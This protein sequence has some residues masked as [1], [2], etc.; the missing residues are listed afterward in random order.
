[1]RLPRHVLLVVFAGANVL[2]S[3]ACE[4]AGPPIETVP[5]PPPGV[6]L[7]CADMLLGPATVILDV[8]DGIIRATTRLP[9]GLPVRIRWYPSFRGSMSPVP[10]II[11]PGG[12]QVRSGD[13][14]WFGGGIVPALDE[15]H[16]CEVHLDEP[17]PPPGGLMERTA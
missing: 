10:H 1:M 8:D 5:P 14:V 6:T 7:T 11:A 17:P 2:A 16:V 9:D 15:I 4:P 13:R 3:A 12:Q